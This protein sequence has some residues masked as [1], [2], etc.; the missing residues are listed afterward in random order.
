VG[1]EVLEARYVVVAAGRKPA[2]LKIPGTEHLT[3][4][5]QFLDLDELPKRI[6]FTGGGYITFKFAH[7]AVRAGARG[8]K[9]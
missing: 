5:T 8:C 4:S 1:G 6:L 9:T 3:T 7:V 2:V